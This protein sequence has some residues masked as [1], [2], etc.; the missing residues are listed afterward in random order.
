[1]FKK[2]INTSLA[3]AMAASA[4]FAA[5]AIAQNSNEAPSVSVRYSD[6]D[7]STREGQDTL[8]RRMRRAAEEVCGIDHRDGIR[9]QSSQVRACYNDVVESFEREIATRVASEQRG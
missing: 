9:L 6:L 1:M 4:M 8:D 2:A 5:P 7:L 3:A